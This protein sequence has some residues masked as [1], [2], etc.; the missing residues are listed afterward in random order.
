[1]VSLD[2]IKELREKMLRLGVREG[3]IIEK[4]VRS[5]GPGGQHVNKVSTCV[6]LR[7]IPTGIEVKCQQ[8]R[9]QA[10]N[11][12]LGWRLLLDKIAEKVAGEK[13]RRRQAIEKIRRQK[14]KRSRRAK[15]RILEAKKK[16]SEKKRS[17][18]FRV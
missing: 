15:E 4:F 11:R 9:S 3:D 18:S 17:R 8:E 2:K 14:R 16:Q 12:F 10:L 5:Q 7:H 6:F 1:M 13:S